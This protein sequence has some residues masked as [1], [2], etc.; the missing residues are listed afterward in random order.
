MILSH[1]TDLLVTLGRRM[2]RA[3][4]REIF[5][6]LADVAVAQ[7]GADGALGIEVDGEGSAAVVARRGTPESVRTLSIKADAVDG[8]L[9][10]A[11]LD[12]CGGRFGSVR[13]LPV[14]DNRALFGALVLLF[15]KPE[16]MGSRQV[17]LARGLVALAATALGRRR[18]A[19]GA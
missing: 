8:T 1:G 6:F 19:V 3:S 9:G 12:A 17:E 10:S 11:L 7:L 16:S 13:T 4:A 15:S 14:A 2:S 18:R 5:P